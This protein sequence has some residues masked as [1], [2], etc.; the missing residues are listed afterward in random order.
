MLELEYTTYR[1]SCMSEKLYIF[2]KHISKVCFV[3]IQSRGYRNRKPIQRIRFLCFGLRERLSLKILMSQYDI[4]MY[5][6]SMQSEIY[7]LNLYLNWLSISY[8]KKLKATFEQLLDFGATFEQL[9]EF[10]SN[11]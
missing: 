2:N 1:D 11:F 8:T 7:L 4:I 9:L 10:W 6:I 3:R 5:V